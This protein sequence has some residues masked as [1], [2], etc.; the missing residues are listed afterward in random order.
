MGEEAEKKND[1]EPVVEAAPVEVSEAQP[2]P[3]GEIAEPVVEVENDD[4]EIV[5]EGT[6][7][8]LNQQAVDSIVQKRVKKLNTKVD[9]AETKAGEVSEENSLLVEK[10][11]LLTLALEQQRNPKQPEV[12]EPNVDDFDLGFDD[13]EFRKKQK[14]YN[15]AQ[16]TAEVRRQVTGATTDF[17]Q[18]NVQSAKQ[19]DLETKQLKHYER[20]DKIGA[21]D[22]M[23][24][25]DKALSIV[26]NEFASQ[27]ISNFDDAHIMLYFLGKNPEE[28]QALADLVKSNPIKGIAEV[29]R[30]RSELKVKPRSNPTPEPDTELEGGVVLGRSADKKYNRL[31][32]EASKTG[33]M[34]NLLAYQRELKAQGKQRK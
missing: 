22:Y 32:E 7:P 20:A 24:V 14:D 2:D 16:I 21:K 12:T 4:V 23:E 11:K 3:V 9:V 18:G 28:A 5:R 34:K 30:L 31:V 19:R 6:Q 1:V 10:N 13:P 29:G 15:T 26:G 25:E 8:L 17:V 33:S 27:M